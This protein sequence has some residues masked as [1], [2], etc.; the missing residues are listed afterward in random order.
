MQLNEKEFVEFLQRKEREVENREKEVRKKAKLI[1]CFAFL[2][3]VAL[4]LLGQHW[5]LCLVAPTYLEP[6]E[7]ETRVLTLHE[8]HWFS[9]DS[10]QRLEVRR[11]DWG[12]DEWMKQSKDGEWVQ[13]F[14]WKDKETNP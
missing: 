12:T 14:E 13:A 5:I 7:G 6:E 11:S 1:T 8:R 9:Q 4:V 3:P 2:T 10:I